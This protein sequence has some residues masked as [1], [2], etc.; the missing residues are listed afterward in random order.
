MP[1]GDGFGESHYDWGDVEVPAIWWDQEADMFYTMSGGDDGM[2]NDDELKM[3]FDSGY[4]E[5][6]LTPDER[7]DAR[8]ALKEYLR[9]EYDINF[10]AA[11]DWEHYREWYAAL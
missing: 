11:F 4:F 7:A 9:E 5:Q 1:G 10:D 6:G 8:K 2:L 3:L